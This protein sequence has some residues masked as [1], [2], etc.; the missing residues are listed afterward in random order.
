MTKKRTNPQLNAFQ[1]Y[2]LSGMLGNLAQMAA[3]H[4][5]DPHTKELIFLTMDAIDTLRNY[6]HKIHEQPRD[7]HLAHRAAASLLA[8][9]THKVEALS[10]LGLAA[11][12]SPKLQ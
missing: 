1:I 7:P 2:R 11:T 8:D 9:L 5:S 3:E 10:N 12:H 6:L 4:H